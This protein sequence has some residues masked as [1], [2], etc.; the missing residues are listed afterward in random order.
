MKAVRINEP[1]NVVLADIEKPTPKAGEALIKIITAG[2]CGS[3]IGAFRGTNNLVSYPRI[4]GHELAGIIESIPEDNPKGLKVGDKV[5]CGQLIAACPQGKLG[6]NIHASVDGTVK[7][8]G[9][10]IVIEREQ[11]KS[12]V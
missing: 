10:V 5:K 8:V 7:S 1:K 9:D 6:A 4:I 3:D 11:V 2:I 12:D